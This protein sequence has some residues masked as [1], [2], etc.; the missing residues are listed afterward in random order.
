VLLRYVPESLPP[1]V[2]LCACFVPAIIAVA[3]VALWESN[4][5]QTIHV[6][7]QNIAIICFIG[8]FPSLVAALL[9]NRCVALLGPA[10]TGASFHLVA[11]YS[12]L[13]AFLFLNEP[14]HF[15]QISGAFLILLG[16]VIATM[17]RSRLRVPPRNAPVGRNQQR[18]AGND[19]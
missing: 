1:L 15:Y 8:I 18:G 12:S 10:I 16:F 19:G 14:I 11:I 17:T 5:G 4:G 2:F 3:P 6:T 13:L 7:V 9:W